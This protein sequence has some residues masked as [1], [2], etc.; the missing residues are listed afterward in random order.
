MHVWSSWSV[1][2]RKVKRKWRE[3][4]RRNASFNATSRN[5]RNRPRPRSENWSSFAANCALAETRLGLY[6]I[7]ECLSAL[8]KKVGYSAMGVMQYLT[9]LGQISFGTPILPL[10]SFLQ[11]PSLFAYTC[12]SVHKAEFFCTYFKIQGCRMQVVHF[13]WHKSIFSLG[14]FNGRKCWILVIGKTVKSYLLFFCLKFL[15]LCTAN[16]V[17]ENWKR[18]A[19]HILGT[20]YWLTCPSV[21]PSISAI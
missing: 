21:F 13:W 4:R 7:H 15:M 19:P 18:W 12:L 8:G 3:W 5:R 17:H 20:G 9:T 16:V 6:T 11:C 14:G 1:K 10:F 2:W